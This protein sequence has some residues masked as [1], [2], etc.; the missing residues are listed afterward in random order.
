MGIVGRLA[1]GIDDVLDLLQAAGGVA[2][3]EPAQQAQVI[4]VAQLARQLLD[5]LGL[6]AHPGHQRGLHREVGLEQGVLG[7]QRL[8][9][10]GTQVVE[11][12][13]QQHRHVAGAGLE[14]LQVVRELEDTAHEDLVGVL[15]VADAIL[16]QGL[17]ELLHLLGHQGSPVEFHHLQGA[18]DLVQVVDAEPELGIVLRRLDVGLQRGACLVEGV[19]DL[20]LHPPESVDVELALAG[21]THGA[22]LSSVSR[23]KAITSSLATGTRSGWRQCTTSPAPRMSSPPGRR[24]STKRL[25][26]SSRRSRRK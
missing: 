26:I 24:C 19:V 20:G 11:Q 10:G 1:Q 7:E 23:R 4:L 21:R 8:A 3:A 14:P 2:V 22:R 5:V 16:Q 6:L 17:G 18:V 15:A 9:A 12:R 25:T 13:Q